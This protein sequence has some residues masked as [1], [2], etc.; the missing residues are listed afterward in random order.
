MFFIQ[1]DSDKTENSFIRSDTNPAVVCHSLGSQWSRVVPA[2]MLLFISEVLPS[3][4]LLFH[5]GTPSEIFVPS[6]QPTHMINPLL[7]PASQI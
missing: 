6:L 5:L 2:A 1:F 7:F 4:D 3:S